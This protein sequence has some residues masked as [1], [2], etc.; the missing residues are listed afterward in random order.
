MLCE[1]VCWERMMYLEEAKKILNQE[2]KEKYALAHTDYQKKF[3]DEKI[4]HSYQVLG[5]GNFLL[6]HEACFAECSPEKKDYYQAIVLLHDIC[7]FYEVL[8]REKGHFINHGVCGGAF[9]AQTKLFNHKD[10]VLSVRHHGHLIERLYEDTDY[11]DLDLE[12]RKHVESIAFLVR[13]ADK[14][15]NLYLLAHDFEKM[16]KIFFVSRYCSHP[17]RK[18]VSDKILEDFM[19]HR[20]VD[21]G[22]ANTFSDFTLIFLG[23][24]YDLRYKSSFV[25]LKK[26]HVIEQLI[27]H[28]SKYWRKRDI[29]IFKKEITTFVQRQ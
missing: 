3:M 29:D 17:F 20:S 7:R 15:A 23:W 8:E 13:D 2:Y 12:E 28:F 19:A 25:F 18:T 11:K 26:L 27:S 21:R 10:A 5:A 24:L 14:L 4:K 1:E 22:N 9:L 6:K 16:R